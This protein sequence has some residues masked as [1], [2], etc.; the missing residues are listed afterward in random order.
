MDYSGSAQ[1]DA[2]A[3][4]VAPRGGMSVGAATGVRKGRRS[5][6]GW[7]LIVWLP[8]IATVIL[9]AFGVVQAFGRM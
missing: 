7:R 4:E 2:G 8:V 1:R 6:R 3:A 9:A 5:S